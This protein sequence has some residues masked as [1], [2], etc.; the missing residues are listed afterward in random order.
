MTS[1][2]SKISL[3]HKRNGNKRTENRQ[4]TTEII[5]NKNVSR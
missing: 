5:S 1:V 2:Y 3:T 4:N